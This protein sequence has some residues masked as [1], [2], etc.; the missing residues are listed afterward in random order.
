MPDD[1][2]ISLNFLSLFFIVYF[3]LRSYTTSHLI[4]TIQSY[5]N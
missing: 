2:L 5:L 4:L 1:I 3:P